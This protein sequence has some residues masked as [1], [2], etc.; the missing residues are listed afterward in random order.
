M[1]VRAFFPRRLLGL[2]V[3]APLH[4]IAYAAAVR[5]PAIGGLFVASLRP[6]LA[7][8]AR[9]GQL[10]FACKAADL[11]AQITE[12]IKSSDVVVYS[13]SYCPFCLKTKA[14]FA[15]LGVTPKII[16]LD[17]VE[18]GSEIQDALASFSG[19][20]TVPNVF[21]HGEHLGGNDDTQKALKSG[22][23][24]EMLKL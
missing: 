9:A 14:V 21:I 3:A 12:T 10:G 23:L 13:K 4:R 16:E 5:A 20:R 8:P 22:K 18:G 19:Q 15:E 1:S 7:V 24:K 6:T 11:T 17:E 2:L